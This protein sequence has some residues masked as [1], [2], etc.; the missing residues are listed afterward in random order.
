MILTQRQQDMLTGHLQDLINAEKCIEVSGV[1]INWVSHLR[2]D[3]YII[4]YSA[5]RIPSN[6]LQTGTVDVRF[7]PQE[8]CIEDFRWANI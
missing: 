1:E 8:N 6:K 5:D 4:R 3:I 2:D 7:T